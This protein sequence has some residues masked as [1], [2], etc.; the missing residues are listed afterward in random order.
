MLSRAT[1]HRSV[2]TITSIDSLQRYDNH[3]SLAYEI[4]TVGLVVSLARKRNE[5]W[6]T[7]NRRNF[8]TTPLPLSR[9]GSRHRKTEGGVR[10]SVEKIIRSRLAVTSEILERQ[11]HVSDPTEIPGGASLSRSSAFARLKILKAYRFTLGTYL[12]SLFSIQL[13]I[14]IRLPLGIRVV[15][16]ITVV[17]VSPESISGYDL[18]QKLSRFRVMT[19]FL[20]TD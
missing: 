8:C 12:L 11:N 10:D 17:T 5:F 15:D 4:F 9:R 13:C 19:V 20:F 7:E 3:D 1:T 18:P 16:G 2:R 6:G 14:S